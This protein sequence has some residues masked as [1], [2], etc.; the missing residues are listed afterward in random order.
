MLEQIRKKTFK[1]N[2]FNIRQIFWEM[3]NDIHFINPMS[4]F[5]FSHKP[6]TVFLMI[7]D[8]F[9]FY[10]SSDSMRIPVYKV[11]NSRIAIH[12]V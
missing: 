1:K 6:K 7:L 12:H 4:I 5:I 9:A 2:L 8:D 3:L 10:V 11:T